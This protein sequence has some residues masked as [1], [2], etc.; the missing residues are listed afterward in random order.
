EV[1]VVSWE[2]YITPDI[3]RAFKADTG[4][5]LRGIPAESDEEMFT[6]LKAGVG[7]QYDIIFCNCGWAPIYHENC[8]VKTIDLKELEA[9]QDLYPIFRE[10]TDLPYL[11]AADEAIMFPNMWAALSMIWNVD[12]FTPS[13]PPSW[14]DLW[15]APKGKV[16]LHGSA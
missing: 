4:I 9:A 3:Q 15:R 14:N 10:N 1:V 2:T 8:M 7:S 16:L 5:T 13:T 6:K 11:T 12:D